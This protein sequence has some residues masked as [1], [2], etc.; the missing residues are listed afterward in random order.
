MM[1]TFD[2]MKIYPIKEAAEL[3]GVAETFLLDLLAKGVRAGVIEP[4][5]GYTVRGADLSRLGKVYYYP[6]EA[7]LHRQ[8]FLRVQARDAEE[9]RERGY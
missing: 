5:H 7:E 9:L 2:P 6:F 8:A 3:V 4:Q 1:A